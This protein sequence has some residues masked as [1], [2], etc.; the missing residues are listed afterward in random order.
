VKSDFVDILACPKCGSPVT[1]ADGDRADEIESGTLR[2]QAGHTFPIVGGVPRFVE[3][4]LYVQNFG[5][6]WNVHAGTQLDSASSDES[7]QAFR[8]KTGFTPEMLAGKLVLDVGCGMGRYTDVA[9]RWGATVVGV[10]LSRAVD[11]AERNVGQRRHVHIAQ[12]NVFE[13][14]FRD[15]TFDFIFSL[16]VLHHTPDTKAA[17]DRLPG[18]LRTNGRIAIWL[19]SNYGGWRPS[20]LYRYVTPRLPKRL[21]HGLTYV[22]VPLYYVHKI[23]IVGPLISFLTPIS[24]H[25]KARW[26]VLDTFDWY[27]PKYQWKHSYEEVFPWFEEQGLT[28]I[29]VLG[30]PIALQGTKR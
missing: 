9:S 26:R 22:A 5:F 3:S 30:S 23:P 21:L 13:L 17:F 20:E 19:Y 7:E 1:V 27:S 11:A 14:P 29:R 2:C 16:G 12:A 15:G 6:E 18:L 25:P 28:D 4:E 8:A 24:H 10:D